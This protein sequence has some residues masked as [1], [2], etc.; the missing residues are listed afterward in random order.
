MEGWYEFI[1][2]LENCSNCH[3]LKWSV[4][5]F[6]DF[7]E[8]YYTVKTPVRVSDLPVYYT[9]LYIVVSIKINT[10]LDNLL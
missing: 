7:G 9:I 10:A 2:Y 6:C 5:S 1:I 8:S 3:G 4:E